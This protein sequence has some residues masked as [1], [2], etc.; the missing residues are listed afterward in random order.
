MICQIEVIGSQKVKN[1]YIFTNFSLQNCYNFS[2]QIE[3]ISRQRVQNCCKIARVFLNNK[4]FQK[5]VF[6]FCQIEGSAKKTQ[7]PKKIPNPF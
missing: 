5:K 4:N 6:F 3:V 1:R 7:N 2:R